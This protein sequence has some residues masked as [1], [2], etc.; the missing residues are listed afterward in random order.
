[1]RRW[2]A[3]ACC[4][5]GSPGAHSVTAQSYDESMHG[6]GPANGRPIFLRD[7]FGSETPVRLSAEIGQKRRISQKTKL[8]PNP[9]RDY[10][11]TP[12]QPHEVHFDGGP[13]RQAVLGA[14]SE[15]WKPLRT[16]VL[17]SNNSIITT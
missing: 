9:A 5:R 13:T 16:L 11:H 10:G 8:S 4:A 12:D 17:L 2:P 6:F 15:G 14:T 7:R 1:M 3:G